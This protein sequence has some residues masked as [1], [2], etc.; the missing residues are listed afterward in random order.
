MKKPMTKTGF[1]LVP[2][3]LLGSLGISAVLTTYI[4]FFF[5]Q[6]PLLSRRES[7]LAL[8]LFLVLIPAAYFILSHLLPQFRSYSSRGQVCWLLLSTLIGFLAVLVTLKLPYFIWSLPKHTI[9]ISIPAGEPDRS[10][11][12][13][14]FTT[15][16]GDIGFGQLEQE[17]GWQ[18]MD[19]GLVHN[20]ASPASL[21]W[22]GR[23]GDSVQI[24]FTGNP[25][26]GSISIAVDGISQQLVLAE[27][28]GNPV[29]FEVSLPLS[30]FNRHLVLFSLWFS[31]SFL[32]LALTLFLVHIPL[33][34]GP[35]ARSRLDKVEIFLLPAK[36]FFF[37]KPG[38]GWWQ[39]RDWIVIILFF[40]T[41]SL[42]FLGRW[43]GLKP[44]VD[45]TG[46]GAYVSAYAASLDN[47][48]VFLSDPM[49][50]DQGNFG[51]YVSL[52]VP[53]VR[54]LKNILG[55]YGSAYVFLLLP[56]VF[57][58]LSGF[59]VFG[60]VF[61]RSRFFALALAVLSTFL[62]NTQSWDY[63]GIYHDPQ[64]RMMF[65]SVLPWLF[66]LVVLSIHKPRLRWLVFICLGL[67]VYVHPVSIPAIAFAI[68]FG[69]LILKPEGT[70]WGRH[71]LELAGFGLI[72]LLFTIPFFMKYIGN[73]DLTT[74]VQV[75]YDTAIAFLKEIIPATFQLQ[76]TQAYM[77]IGIFQSGLVLLAYLGAITVFRVGKERTNLGMLLGWLAGILIV[78]I[79]FSA[80]ELQLEQRL[81]I[82]PV[83]V[84]ISRG[85]RYTVPLL[86]I[87]V[88]WPL[89]LLWEQVV[90][91]Q[92]YP[93]TRR[94]SLSVAA[95]LLIVFF[96]LSFPNSFEYP[97]PDYRFKS[98]ECY[99]RGQITC[100]SQVLLDQAAVIEF[101]RE[102]TPIGSRLIS[103][104]PVDIGG[105]IRFQ[106]LRP[107]AFDQKDMLRLAMGDVA[108]AIALR[109]DNQVWE[110]IPLLP[111]EEQLVPYLKFARRRNADFAVIQNPAP[112]WLEEK[113]VYSNT[114][115]S[116]LDLR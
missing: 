56:F 62:I 77:L 28:A 9:E 103:I 31:V 10:I 33:R 87:L 29:K 50:K 18:R 85:L 53:I 46:D 57:L 21:H 47:P 97:I 88:L 25:E 80:F 24:V 22:S 45:L 84:Q 11:T 67:M 68:W 6:T 110:N 104:P 27:P 55:D 75:D 112:A 30:L 78:C 23:A 89:A 92:D 16:L 72:F 36:N 81:R 54:S 7:A 20:E 69:Y 100:P 8:L 76:R 1:R 108:G 105:A 64:P 66:A 114:T 107:L 19:A 43:N 94:L 93:V 58:Q 116:L 40:L 79:G 82:L 26:A 102:E 13:Q 83:L 65:Q 106:S 42:F 86:E 52:Q 48:Q 5:F 91:G 60:R 99:A 59:Y 4:Y 113:V 73:R 34:I 74:T 115:Y 49:L 90:T 2:G 109:N 14:W 95:V 98:F 3:R 51:W 111:A 63:W 61:Y 37:P 41:A 70:K 71:I 15:S 35:K 96:Y 101:I 39:G 38:K 12:L 17:G 44:F 32:F